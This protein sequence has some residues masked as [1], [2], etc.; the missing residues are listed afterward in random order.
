MRVKDL[1]YRFFH[2]IEAGV[3]GILVFLF[4]TIGNK[5]H[6]GLGLR[7]DVEITEQPIGNAW[8]TPH[9][10]VWEDNVGV[11]SVLNKMHAF[12]V[13]VPK[14]IPG[15]AVLTIIAPTILLKIGEGN[16]FYD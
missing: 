5:N 9:R 13:R 8:V 4:T 1:K 14:V 11:G 7:I 2:F 6:P 3:L 15:I 12:G 16:G 10:S